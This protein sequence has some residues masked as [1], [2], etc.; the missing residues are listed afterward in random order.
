VTDPD[1][2]P[3]TITINQIKQ[4]EPTDC[5]GDGHTCPDGQGIGTSDA[6]VRAERSG[7]GNGRV[8]TI[9]FTARDGRGGS[10]QNSVAV[11]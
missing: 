7:R 1:R 5:T 11:C 8:Y 3:V 6:Q 9:F 10:C 4:D 2:D